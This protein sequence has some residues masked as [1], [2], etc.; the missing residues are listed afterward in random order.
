MTERWIRIENLDLGLKPRHYR[1]LFLFHS[2]IV[3]AGVFVFLGV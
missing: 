2:F 3:Q 1:G